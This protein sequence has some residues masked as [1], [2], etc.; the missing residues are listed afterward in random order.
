MIRYNKDQSKDYVITDFG[1]A[2]W[3]G[4]KNLIY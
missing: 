3:I 1:L 2:C 4:E